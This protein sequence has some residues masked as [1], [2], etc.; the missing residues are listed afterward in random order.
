MYDDTSAFNVLTELQGKP[1]DE[2]VEINK[3]SRLPYGVCVINLVGDLNTGIIIRSA[4]LMGAERVVVFGKRKYDRRSTVGS[5]CYIDIDRVDGYEDSELSADK[6]MEVMNK[7]NYIPV[8][9]ETG[10]FDIQTVLYDY[11]K[12]IYS[13]GK[14]ICLVLG[15]EGVG[16]PD[17]IRKC[18]EI[19]TIPQ[20]GIIR[21]MNVSSAASIALWEMQKVF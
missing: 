21:S 12:M 3:Q 16:I 18:G 5:H 13:H 1:Y 9:I 7:Y 4:N 20:R 17:E 2:L 11:S 10:G 8:M 6:F 14:K 19:F 15:N